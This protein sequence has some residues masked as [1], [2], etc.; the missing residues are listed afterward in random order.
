MCLRQDSILGLTPKLVLFPT[1]LATPSE[2]SQICTPHHLPVP[3]HLSSLPCPYLSSLIL[4]FLILFFFPSWLIYHL[5]TS[6]Y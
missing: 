5:V 2:A 3:L 4:A 6:S 1:I